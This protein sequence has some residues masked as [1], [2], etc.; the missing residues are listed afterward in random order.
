MNLKK[1]QIKEKAKYNFDKIMSKGTISLVIVLSILTLIVTIVLGIL[2]FLCTRDRTL[3]ETIWAAFTN[4]LDPGVVSAAEY[5]DFGFLVP[6]LLATLFGIFFTAILIGIITQGISDKVE[7]LRRGQSKILDKEH[8]LIIG[9]NERVFNIIGQLLFSFEGSKKEHHTI[10]ILGNEDKT[11]MEDGI[12]RYLKSS[13]MEEVE[14]HAYNDAEKYKRKMAKLIKKQTII[15]RTGELGDKLALLNCN[16]RFARSIIINEFNDLATMKTLLALNSISQ[17]K[18]LS[19]NDPY[20]VGVAMRKENAELFRFQNPGEWQKYIL[21]FSDQISK[22]TARSC[23]H[24][25]VSTAFE[26]LFDFGGSEIYIERPRGYENLFY[27]K[28]EDGSIVQNTYTFGEILNRVRRASVIGYKRRGELFINPDLNTEIFAS[29]KLIL[30]EEQQF[31]SYIFDEPNINV[32]NYNLYKEKIINE[33]ENILVLGS[34]PN[35]P[36]I[37]AEANK[38]LEDNS[39]VVIAC[40]YDQLIEGLRKLEVEKYDINLHNLKFEIMSIPMNEAHGVEYYS[41]VQKLL[42]E[43]IVYQNRETISDMSE[44][45][46]KCHIDIRFKL[47]DIYSSDSFDVLLTKANEFLCNKLDHILVLS[48]K[49]LDSDTADEKTL[50]LL[51][52]LRHRFV[53]NNVNITTEMRKAANQRIADNSSVDD[54]IISDT[55]VSNMVTQIAKNKDLY[56]VFDDI[57]D[58]EGSE[59]YLEPFRNYIMFN[60]NKR[61]EF[62]FYEIVKIV[63]TK[64]NRIPIGYRRT[65]EN[66]VSKIVLNPSKRLIFDIGPNDQVIVVAREK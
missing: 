6:M 50:F 11:T 2:S 42:K 1:E 8:F 22:I 14:G 46:I 16:V 9:Y 12:R 53:K 15:C 7:Q 49:T 47:T 5:N 3:G 37:L 21:Y 18:K 62:N 43:Y 38:Y 4:M 26:D 44:D 60:E 52:N 45:E 48:D 54:F 30:I 58:V 31:D 19:L 55:I 25:G 20:I 35:L 39:M 34:N 13:F 64:S 63:T 33:S 65:D 40:N 51:M 10:V 61:E 41:K 28:N 66:G 17:E 24:P 23:L 27:T 29:D 59:V 32:K 36:Q 56:A 57:L